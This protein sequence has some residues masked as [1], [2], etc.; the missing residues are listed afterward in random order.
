M[1]YEI[2]YAATG[3]YCISFGELPYRKVHNIKSPPVTSQSMF[4]LAKGARALLEK[5]IDYK[6]K[7]GSSTDELLVGTLHR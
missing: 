5:R 3:G 1:P 7:W 2:Y 4:V 6:N